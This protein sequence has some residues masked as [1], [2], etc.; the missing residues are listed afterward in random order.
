VL[1]PHDD[2]VV[3]RAKISLAAGHFRVFSVELYDNHCLRATIRS[4]RCITK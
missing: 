2:I 3:S 1:H 4:N